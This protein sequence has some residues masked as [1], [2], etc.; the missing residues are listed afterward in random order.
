MPEALTDS[1]R[2]AG[3]LTVAGFAAAGALTVLE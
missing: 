2:L 3:P 1:G